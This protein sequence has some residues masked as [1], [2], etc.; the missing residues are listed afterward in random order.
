MNVEQ[1]GTYTIFGVSSTGASVGGSGATSVTVVPA[2]FRVL[3]IPKYLELVR[4]V[5]LSDN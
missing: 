3:Q 1:A 5:R 2:F 4:V